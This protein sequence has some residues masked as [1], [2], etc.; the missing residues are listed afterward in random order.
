MA[1]GAF[2]L[3]PSDRGV[4][5]DAD[6][7]RRGTAAVHA[8]DAPRSWIR[9]TGRLKQAFLDHLASTRDV[10]GSARAI[11]VDPAS[12]YYL[13]RKDSKFA[14]EWAA[15]LVLGYQMLETRLVGHVLSGGASEAVPPDAIDGGRFDPDQAVRALAMYRQVVKGQAERVTRG[16]PRAPRATNAETNALLKRKLDVLARRLRESGE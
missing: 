8:P 13:R 14:T 12:V 11:G 4:G 1:K 16:G 9:W 6:R 7:R 5:D 3:V 15:A 10:Q 2:E